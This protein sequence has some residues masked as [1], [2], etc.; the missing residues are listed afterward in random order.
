MCG[1]IGL[2]KGGPGLQKKVGRKKGYFKIGDSVKFHFIYIT[3]MFGLGLLARPLLTI[4][5]FGC[6]VLVCL[7]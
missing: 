2:V 3:Y 6:F 7:C 4:W 5:K 1:R